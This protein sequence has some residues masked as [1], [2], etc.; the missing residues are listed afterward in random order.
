MTMAAAISVSPG[1]HIPLGRTT[2]AERIRAE[3]EVEEEVE[4][5]VEGLEGSPSPIKGRK[6]G[7]GLGL[8]PKFGV[9]VMGMRHGQMEDEENGAFRIPEAFISVNT[10]R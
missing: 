7:A 3:R 10:S 2:H 9:R 4:R 5:G 6:E 1:S 8:V